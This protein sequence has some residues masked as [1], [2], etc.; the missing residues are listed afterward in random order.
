MFIPMDCDTCLGPALDNGLASTN[1]R[2]KR[3]SLWRQGEGVT[4]AVPMEFSQHWFNREIWHNWTIHSWHP[5]SF[6][7]HD[8]NV[9]KL[10][11]LSCLSLGLEQA[12]L[13]KWQHGED[14]DPWPLRLPLPP[15]PLR[16]ILQLVIVQVQP[17]EL[18]PQVCKS[19][20]FAVWHQRNHF[21][22]LHRKYVFLIKEQLH[23]RR[24]QSSQIVVMKR[25]VLQL[26]RAH[27]YLQIC[28]AGLHSKNLGV[29]PWIELFNVFQ[30]AIYIYIYIYK[31]I[32]HIYHIYIYI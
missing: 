2:S 17:L 18:L 27:G 29:F 9:P 23:H 10:V 22:I 20:C 6:G 13:W 3:G 28:I 5:R 19:S 7:P 30:L 24:W 4:V 11:P 21:R 32:I 26:P 25:K 1:S 15:N 31:Y 8:E 12:A 14:P 16:Q